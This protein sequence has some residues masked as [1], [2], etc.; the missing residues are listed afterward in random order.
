LLDQ[1]GEHVLE[2]LRLAVGQRPLA[3]LCCESRGLLG[4]F[5]LPFLDTILNRRPLGRRSRVF[6]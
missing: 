5:A 6:I 2:P 4:C 1:A 3:T